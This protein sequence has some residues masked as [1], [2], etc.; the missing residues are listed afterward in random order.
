MAMSQLEGDVRVGGNL[1]CKTFTPP[2]SCIRNAS[3]EALAGV[4]ATKLEHRHQLTFAQANTAAT[5]ETRAV[6]VVHGTTG[7][8]TAFRAGSIAKA[9]GDATCTVDLLKNGVSALSSVITLDSGNTNRV[10]ED[11][12]IS[13]PSLAEGDLL[14]IVIDGTIGTGTLP[15]GVYASLVVTEDAV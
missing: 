9:V 2:S 1:S 10:A 5:D 12:T 13:T 11:G 3:I 4:S 6:H 15:T 8:I 14:E 7:T